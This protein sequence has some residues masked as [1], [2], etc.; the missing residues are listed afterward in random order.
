MNLI[1]LFFIFQFDLKKSNVSPMDPS[2]AL[3]T[4]LFSYRHFRRVSIL[5]LP[6]NCD[7]RILLSNC[8][9]KKTRVRVYKD[10]RIPDIEEN[11]SRTAHRKKKTNPMVGE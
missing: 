4:P 2:V 9:T 10:K 8:V 5:E 6:I 3:A 1:L 7:S 11:S